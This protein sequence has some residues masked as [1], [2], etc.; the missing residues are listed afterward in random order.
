MSRTLY[1]PFHPTPL[2]CPFCGEPARVWVM[3][4]FAE[5]ADTGAHQTGISCSN[6]DGCKVYAHAYD[7]DPVVAISRW[8]TRMSE[9]T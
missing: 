9:P 1:G 5:D 6:P 4:N 7:I 8:N 2:P 3:N